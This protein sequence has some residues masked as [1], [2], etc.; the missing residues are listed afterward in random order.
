MTP[1]RTLSAFGLVPG[2]PIMESDNSFSASRASSL[3]RTITR[4]RP[5]FSNSAPSSSSQDLE[6]DGAFSMPARAAAAAATSPAARA[7][8]V[9]KVSSS[10]KGAK[11]ANG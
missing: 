2:S 6:P 3:E 8:H 1:S 10:F 7:M 11:S 9:F 4:K 5:V